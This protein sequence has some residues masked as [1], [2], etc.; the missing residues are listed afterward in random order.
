MRARLYF[1]FNKKED[2]EQFLSELENRNFAIDKF[3]QIEWGE[4]N[5]QW[6]LIGSKGFKDMEE[7]NTTEDELAT[8]AEKC[9]GEFDGNEI[10]L[11]PGSEF[12]G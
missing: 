11:D 1:Y 12:G 6:S 3:A 7:L 9:H 8:I 5:V 2:G 10:A 4:A